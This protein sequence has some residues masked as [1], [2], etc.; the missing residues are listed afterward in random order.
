MGSDPKEEPTF[1]VLL[2]F[3]NER[4]R[5]ATAIESVQAQTYADWE[6]LAV[7][8]GSTDDSAEIVAR[9]AFRDSRIRLVRRPHG[10]VSAA[11]NAGIAAARG[12][13]CALL[14]ADDAWLPGKLERQLPLL[15]ERTVVFSDAWVE[16]EGRRFR[17]ARRVNQPDGVF[18]RGDV[19]DDLV[20]QDFVCVS[21]TVVPT[22]L[23]RDIGSFDETVA[24]S[25]DWDLWLRLSLAGVPFEYAQ[26]PLAVYQV[27]AGSLSSDD[28]ALRADAVQVLRLLC[29]KASGVRRR[30]AER[31]LK[32]ARR[33]L[34][35]YL[36]KRAWLAAAAGDTRSARRD[37]AK[38]LKSN[39]RSPRALTGILLALVPPLLAR[40]A[41]RHLAPNLG[42]A[43]L[44]T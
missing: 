5:V 18:P 33:E 6:L 24:I 31:R 12:R 20:R 40:Y 15:D 43:F 2:A 17:W 9:Y 32:L 42:G 4:D 1:S 14:D 41:R 22:R 30:T 34:E 7:D 44:R 39:P 37:L 11:R 21:T 16:E 19:F 28:E 36:R 8:D 13:Y 27:R 26:E 10:G 29:A 3:F 25:Q 35:V 38:S 23:I